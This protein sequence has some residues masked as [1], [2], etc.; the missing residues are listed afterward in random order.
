M[1]VQSEVHHARP[2]R[3][4]ARLRSLL[5]GGLLPSETREHLRSARR[6]QLLAA[7]SLLDALISRMERGKEGRP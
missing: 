7:R 1:S 3:W 4:W 2:R 5:T 6:E